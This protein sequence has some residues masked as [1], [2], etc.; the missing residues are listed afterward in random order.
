[1]DESFHTILLRVQDV[2]FVKVFFRSEYMAVVSWIVNIVYAEV[3]LWLGTTL[4]LM[5]VLA[6]KLELDQGLIAVDLP[7]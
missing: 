3:R 2:Y 6:H 1:V 7:R 5:Q 4:Q